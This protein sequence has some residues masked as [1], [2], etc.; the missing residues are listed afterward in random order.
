MCVCVRLFACA[1]TCV[2]MHVCVCA[3]VCVHLCVCLRMHMLCVHG[4]A[5]VKRKIMKHAAPEDG[6]CDTCLS[7]ALLPPVLGE[8]NA[9]GTDRQ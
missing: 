2:C 1:C 3:G 8:G 6:V 5:C 9:D 7:R 4:F